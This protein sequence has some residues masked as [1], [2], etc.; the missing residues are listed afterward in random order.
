M[1][2][3]LKP[4]PE[5]KDSGLPW[6]EEVPKHWALQR[7]KTVL[8][9]RVEKGFPE[10]PLLAA[11]QNKGVVK[12]EHYENRTVEAQKD[13]HLLKLVHK[14]DF[15]ISLRSFQGGIEYAHARGIISPAYTILQTEDLQL[16]SYLSLL[17]KS[18]PY[19]ENL[20][21]HVTGIRQ[22]QNIDYEKLSRS[23]IPIP[24]QTEQT[25][26]VRF[27][28]HYDKKIRR[29]IRAKQ[30]LIKLLEEQ[31][32]VI[33]HRAVTRGLNPDAPLKSS[34]IPW[35]GEIPAHW[36][37]TP[38]KSV[39]TIQSGVTLGKAYLDAQLQEF[40]YLS[41]ANVQ[42]GYLSLE[43][44]KTLRLPALE[45]KRSILRDGDV[46]MTE[47]GDP[48]KLGRG[49]V[50]NGEIENCLHQNHIFAVRPLP[51]KLHPQYLAAILSTHYAKNY[52]MRTA[53]QTTNLAS[54]NKTTISQFRLPLPSII[55]QNQILTGVAFE[56]N[57]IASAVAQANHEISLIKEYWIRLTADIVTGKLDVHEAAAWLPEEQEE[58]VLF[59]EDV[60]LAKDD[61]GE[62]DSE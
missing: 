55:E 2:A 27:L 11:T 22:G 60:S 25:A 6:L 32:Q 38:L 62:E 26:I 39:C 59:D 45:A 41:V 16:H 20:N 56:I 47:G 30:K 31:K 24:S 29:Y 49:C 51:E 52:F 10:E 34:G 57:S 21:L 54:T 18:K 9:E 4:Y 44:I 8:H 46:L 35:L 28:N 58:E 15:V 40:P 13:L 37:I 61:V 17:F 43:K 5:Y 1:I 12:K 19:I 50:W 23:A 7:M 3:D 33:I 14:N 42:A 53:K 48:D 36:E